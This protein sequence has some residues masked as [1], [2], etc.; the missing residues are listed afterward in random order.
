[1]NHNDNGDEKTDW[2]AIFND[3]KIMMTNYVPIIQEA[4][5]ACLQG[6][7]KAEEMGHTLQTIALLH[8]DL[9]ELIKNH[10]V[11]KYFTN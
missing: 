10:E 6:A 11:F 8:Q 2:E 3:T 4:V 5:L 9:D 7:D 1:M